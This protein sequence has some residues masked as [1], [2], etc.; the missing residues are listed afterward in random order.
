MNQCIRQKRVAETY[1][2]TLSHLIHFEVD[3][4]A[5][6]AVMI[7]EVILSPDLR[8]AKIYFTTESGRSGEKKALAGFEETKIF[9]KKRLADSVSLKFVPDLKFYYDESGDVRKNM[10]ALFKKIEDEK[11]GQG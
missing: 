11:R 8:L 6:D 7:T 9:L 1:H 3:H 2:H 5:L 4:P 10:D